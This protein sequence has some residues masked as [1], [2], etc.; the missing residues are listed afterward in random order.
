M[1]W[2]LVD[3]WSGKQVIA[4]ISEE[5]VWGEIT[6]IHFYNPETKQYQVT[7]PTVNPPQEVGLFA[8]AENLSKSTQVMKLRVELR[9]PD[10]LLVD[11]DE[12]EMDIDY[13]GTLGSHNVVGIAT[14][15]GKYS[16]KVDLWV[17]GALVDSKTVVAANVREEGLAGWPW[18][19]WML[20]VAGGV[21][22]VAAIKKKMSLA[23]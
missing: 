17:A 13:P 2:T 16:G 22:V 11:Y 5:E 21:G 7:P 12:R 3:Q 10:G 23:K 19:A 14:K 18:W 1:A 4:T 15:K 6:A 20:A 8:L 9:D